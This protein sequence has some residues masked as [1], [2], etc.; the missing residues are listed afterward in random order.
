MSDKAKDYG[1]PWT[2]Q[3]IE[4]CVFLHDRVG[5][6]VAS[7]GLDGLESACRVLDT[8]SALAG[9]PNPEE[10]VRE[11]RE[12]HENEYSRFLSW[13]GIEKP[14]DEC[15]GRGSKAYSNTATWRGGVGGQMVTEGVCSA[16]WGSGDALRK[17][18]DL[19]KLGGELSAAQARVGELEK[20]LRD[21]SMLSAENSLA[22]E[23]CRQ[24]MA[25]SRRWLTLELAAA[26]D[27]EVVLKER[28]AQLEAQLAAVKEQLHDT[29]A[30][31]AIAQ[32]AGLENWD[33]P[34]QIERAVLALAARKGGENA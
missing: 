10:F 2:V 17:G 31:D 8:I 20:A 13:R 3:E 29:S 1:E 16:C 14:C 21:T 19:R 33:Y 6:V 12:R 7:F 27:A 34:A 9:I 25:M 11:A 15:G 18:A 26:G 22:L 24:F 5:R 28:I 4:G 23:S 32:A 30:L